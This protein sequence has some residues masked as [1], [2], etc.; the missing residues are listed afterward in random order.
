[1]C[2]LPPY[3]MQR[4]L[5]PF[6][7]SLRYV[8][9][10]LS[11][12][13]SLPPPFPPLEYRSPH[14][15]HTRILTLSL[16]S[17][18]GLQEG[19][20]IGVF[21]GGGGKWREVSKDEGLDCGIVVGAWLGR[22]KE[23]V[24]KQQLVVN[25]PRN[26]LA[27]YRVPPKTLISDVLTM[28]CKDRCL[29]LDNHEI[30]HPV[31]V[32]E[33]LRGSCTLA[34]YQLQEVCV[35]PRDFRAPPLSVTDLITMAAIS[36]PEDKKR[37]TLLSLF[38][39]KT[40]SSTG[41]SSLSSGSAGERSVSPARSDESADG[42]PTP[43]PLSPASSSATL[44]SSHPPPPL[45]RPASSLN[46]ARARK[47]QAPAPP[48]AAPP[49]AAAPPAHHTNGKAESERREGVGSSLSRRS[50]DSSGYHE[51]E[52]RSPHTSPA[53]SEISSLETSRGPGA[54]ATNLTSV[55]STSSLSLA[56]SRGKRRAPP[57]PKPAP[58]KHDEARPSAIPEEAE[59]PVPAKASE[60]AAKPRDFL[61]EGNIEDDWNDFLS[62]LGEILQTQQ[63]LVF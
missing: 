32:D 34:D 28:V 47:R 33:K 48:P 13:Y 10:P 35:V 54:A 60:E 58:A 19:W 4:S 14:F 7:L 11:D 38:S 59:T 16:P 23:Y 25:L 51:S 12:I 3:V 5:H 57:P 40:K 6:L 15:P 1:M 29:D 24:Y 43:R 17:F 45:S 62:D 20:G 61:D 44:T 22:P 9:F 49:P 46:L 50:S 8:A 42:R 41:D 26:Q 36:H 27:V 53:G 31:N 55:V 39:R 56:S 2:F 21:G 37:R 63:K 52:H 18:T 30:R